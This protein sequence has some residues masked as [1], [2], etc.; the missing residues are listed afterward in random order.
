MQGF[1][2]SRDAWGTSSDLYP[3]PA[4]FL[5]LLCVS[6]PFVSQLLT[7]LGDV[8]QNACINAI[9]LKLRH[10]RWSEFEWLMLTDSFLAAA[11][12]TE[13]IRAVCT[14]TTEALANWLTCHP[15]HHTLFLSACLRKVVYAQ[16]D[17]GLF[18]DLRRS[19]Q[20]ECVPSST[21]LPPDSQASLP[22]VGSTGR[23]LTQ[24]S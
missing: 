24:W 16:F 21:E 13:R 10:W 8:P 3:S 19:P 9:M 6:L 18:Y 11:A 14:P 20:L 7:D 22:E 17:P 23:T 5:L 4:A 15:D 1:Q 2:P 12:R